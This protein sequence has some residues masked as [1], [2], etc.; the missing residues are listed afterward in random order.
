[1]ELVWATTDYSFMGVSY[2]GC[3][4]LL[5]RYMRSV[6]VANRFL[7]Y[8]LLHRGRVASSKS[9]R[10]VGQ[11][12][13]DYF[14]FLEKQDLPWN[15]NLMRGEI[16]LVAAYRDYCV[17]VCK[18]S[19]RTINQRLST[20][21]SFYRYA[22]DQG[23]IGELPFSD[24]QSRGPSSK[25]F[26][27]HLDSF[28]G[29]VRSTDVTV[30]LSKR[31]LAF[32]S[33]DEIKLLLAETANPTHKLMIRMGLQ[34]G[35]RREEIATF[36]VSYVYKPD[37]STR[38]QGFLKIQLDPHDGSGM[39]TKGSRPREVAMSRDL[40]TDLWHYCVHERAQLASPRDKTRGPLFLSGR[41]E[42]WAE[43]GKGFLTVLRRLGAA[44]GIK[45]WPHL[46]RHSY[47]TYTLAALQGRAQAFEPLVFLQKQLGHSSID[48]TMIYAH[49]VEGLVEEAVIAYDD[50]VTEWS[51][52]SGQA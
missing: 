52:A 39:K 27:A 49:L 42:P 51:R 23:W 41:G 12:L 14:G 50:E 45:V 48:T 28:G 40:M 17:C 7:R 38:R 21:A 47:A 43:D 34:V 1:M 10:T 31:P 15:G 11:H 13:Y 44:V 30:P 9:W 8:Y 6:E 16:G 32:L 18:L 2:P 26:L 4:I 24:T 20:I 3:P 35:L 46:L 5:D 36:P 19:P 22:Q 29:R 37:T 25:G 33:R